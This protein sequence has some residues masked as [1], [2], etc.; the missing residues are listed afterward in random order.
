MVRKLEK[1]QRETSTSCPMIGGG[2]SSRPEGR[3]RLRSMTPS[4]RRSTGL[5]GIARNQGS[6]LFIHRRDGTIRERGLAWKRPISHREGNRACDFQAADRRVAL[7]VSRSAAVSPIRARCHSRSRQKIG[8]TALWSIPWSRIDSDGRR[9]N[10][11]MARPQGAQVEIAVVV[12]IDERQRRSCRYHHSTNNTRLA[13]RASRMPGHAD[14]ST[15]CGC[16]SPGS[17]LC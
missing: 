8:D 14:G 5:G 10:P 16:D 13:S 17:I 1:C 4:E 2:P 15:E 9:M 11:I 7:L 12:D 6:E 3:N